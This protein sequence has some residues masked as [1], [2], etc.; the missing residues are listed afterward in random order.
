MRQHGG[1]RHCA[2]RTVR[3]QYF[4]CACS[5]CLHVQRGVLRGDGFVVGAA[6][7]STIPVTTAR[8][9][10]GAIDFGLSA[11]ESLR[12]PFLMAFG[13]SVLLEEGTW[14]EAQAAQF[15][16]LGHEELVIRQA[17][18]KGGALLRVGNRWESARDPRLEGDLDMP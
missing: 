13:D 6:G 1:G 18:I 8:A 5:V 10:V 11:E 4:V 14:L 12:L 7:G 2:T 17:P 9:I 16:A 3:A 15:R